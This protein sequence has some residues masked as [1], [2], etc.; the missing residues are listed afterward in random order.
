MDSASEPWM[1][2]E[3]ISVDAALAAYTSG[4]A[5]QSGRDDAGVIRPGARADLTLLGE[6]PR[7]CD[8]MH[9]DRIDVL[10]TWRSGVRTFER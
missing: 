7:E 5:F 4:V 10:G 2:E 6:D 9:I 8:P 1:P 3:R